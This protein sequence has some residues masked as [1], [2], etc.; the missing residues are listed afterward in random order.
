MVEYGQ[1]PHE[2]VV[3]LYPRIPIHWPDCTHIQPVGIV[4]AEDWIQYPSC[5]KSFVVEG[6]NGGAPLL[7]RTIAAVDDDVLA[8][9]GM[10]MPVIAKF[11]GAWK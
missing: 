1:D 10:V 4:L 6:L 11:V 9:V 7:N 2:L 5:V 3:P 8:V